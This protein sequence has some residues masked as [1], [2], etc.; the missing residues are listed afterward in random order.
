MC[1]TGQLARFSC[2]ILGNGPSGSRDA[3]ELETPTTI[4]IG[5]TWHMIYVGTGTA[6]FPLKRCLGASLLAYGK[7]S[8]MLSPSGNSLSSK[9]RLSGVAYLR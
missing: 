9:S 2:K 7:N 6:T 1:S 8:S 3:E 5:D 4:V